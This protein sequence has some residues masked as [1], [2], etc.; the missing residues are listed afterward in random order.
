[1]VFIVTVPLLTHIVLM[2]GQ[3][4]RAAYGLIFG[5]AVFACWFVLARAKPPYR[6]PAIAG[7]VACSIALCFLHLTGGLV[8]SSGVPHALAYS[9]LLILFGA[10]LLPRREPIVTYFARKIHGPPSTEIQKYTRHVTWAWCVFFGLQLLGSAVLIV[11]AP[12]AWW[13]AFVN[14][15]NAPLVVVMFLSERLFRPLWLVNPP[16]EHFADIRHMVELA[17]GSLTKRGPGLQ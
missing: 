15:L 17:N 4:G 11:L 1:M 6:L 8:L 3:P 10:S 9:S 13:S 2:A 14:V 7:L 16:F 5:Q 12:V